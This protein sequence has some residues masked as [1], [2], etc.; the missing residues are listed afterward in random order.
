MRVAMILM[1]AVMTLGLGAATLVDGAAQPAPA[2]NVAQSAAGDSVPCGCGGPKAIYAAQY[3][4]VQ[5]PAL[6]QRTQERE[7][8]ETADGD[9]PAT[10]TDAA[11]GG[12][13]AREGSRPPIAKPDRQRRSVALRLYPDRRAEG[14]RMRLPSILAVPVAL[15]LMLSSPASADDNQCPR[16]AQA[17]AMS[18][19]LQS[20]AE[21]ATV[22]AAETSA[23]TLAPTTESTKKTTTT[24]PTG[25]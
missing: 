25:G 24:T 22:P 20:Q 1:G 17:A 7:A 9:R 2:Q 3:G 13:Q 12:G 23:E 8:A 11:D 6:R 5:P 21:V 10:E 4:T 16:A 18:T 19:Y 15:G 14:P